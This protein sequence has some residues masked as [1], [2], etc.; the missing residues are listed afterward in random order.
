[1]LY[2][3]VSADDRGRDGRNLAGQL[4]MGREYA[5]AN[6]W[7]I[8]AE[9]QEDDRGASG[10]TLELPV[11]Q[12][13]IEMAEDGHIDVLVVREIDRLSRKLIKQLVVEQRLRDAGVAVEYV[14]GDYP[15]TPE[16][17][18]NKLIRAVI[19]EYERAKIGERMERGRW[20]KVKA[21]SVMLYGLKL[22]GYR[23]VV[24]GGKE[25]L[26]IVEDEARIIRQMFQWY[27]HGDDNGGPM[28]IVAIARRLSEMGIVR[29]LGWHP[30]ATRAPEGFW[31]RSTVQ[32]MLKRE[33]YA[34]RWHYNS[35]YRRPL[36][37]E[38]PAIIS[39]ELWQ[40]ARERAVTNRQRAA[41]NVRHEYLWRGRV[42][43]GEC[44]RAM[45]GKSSSPDRRYYRCPAAQ[46]G[47]A[48]DKC[49][50]RSFSVETIDGAAWETI[51]AWIQSPDRLDALVAAAMD[52]APD[53]EVLETRAA[54]LDNLLA[55][56][57]DQMQRLL[58]LY[59]V[60]RFNMT[61]LTEREEAL[62]RE[63]ELMSAEKERLEQQLGQIADRSG[64]QIRARLADVDAGLLAAAD[65]AM[66]RR[67]LDVLDVRLVLRRTAEGAIAISISM[68]D[69]GTLTTLV[70]E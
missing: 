36:T 39:Q 8:V 60:G 28:G 45:H 70:L 49:P 43:C 11:L 32:A 2:A 63:I 35:R 25:N 23:T 27:V 42:T 64:D 16:G 48:V 58:D 55:K 18:L 5:E 59:L 40:A 17:Q 50:S 7:R 53:T 21:G 65:F 61:M 19:A 26:E 56:K 57:R 47:H 22:Y 9:L 29:N 62:G 34:G 3:R 37:V 33:A 15:D 31:P 44:G 30:H 69:W 68:C 51:T 38:V 13:I 10:A 12:R 41:R 14:L 1:V 6:G 4:D 24:E 46:A 20:Q 66:K 54:S 52:E 67:V